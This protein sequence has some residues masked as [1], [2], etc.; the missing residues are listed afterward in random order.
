MYTIVIEEDQVPDLELKLALK[1]E[2]RKARALELAQE[3]AYHRNSYR[4][5]LQSVI[6]VGALATSTLS[7]LA[8]EIADFRWA[9]AVSGF[10]LEAPY[11]S[12]K[13]RRSEGSRS[14]SFRISLPS[15][16]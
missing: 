13:R 6:I 14:R 3:F 8:V 10:T 5:S 11:F 4:G 7:S 9:A 1:K 12:A 2:E 16:L 15:V